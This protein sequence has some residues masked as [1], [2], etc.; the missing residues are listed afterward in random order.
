VFD[1]SPVST[2]VL[3]ALTVFVTSDDCACAAE[4][5]VVAAAPAIPAVA[6]EETISIV[7]TIAS[8]ACRRIMIL[9]ARAIAAK[10]YGNDSAIKI[11]TTA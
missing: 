4:S 11:L 6:T 2:A 1:V 9:A 8:N 7:S 5:D 10:T 3:S